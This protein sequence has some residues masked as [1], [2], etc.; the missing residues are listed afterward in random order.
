MPPKAAATSATP[1]AKPKPRA[2][3]LLLSPVNN[4]QLANLCGVLDENALDAADHR[5]GDGLRQ[6]LDALLQAHQAF[7]LHF[8]RRVVGE[9]GGGCPGAG[10]VEEGKRRVETDIVDELHRF[11]EILGSLAREADD[12]V[13]RQRQVGACGAQLAH[14]TLV[15]DRG[16]AALHRRQHAVRSRLDR[17]VQVRDQF[18]NTGINVDQSL[19]QLARMRGGVADAFDSGDLGDVFDDQREVGLFFTAGHRATV[20]IDV[21]AEQ[22]HFLDALRGQAGD[23]GEHVVEGAR[24]FLAAGVGDD[25]ERTELAAALHDRD[26]GRRA[27]DL[28]RRQIVELLDFRERDVDLRFAQ[29]APVGDH[30][31]QAMQRLRAENHVDVGGAGDDRRAFLAGDAAADADHQVGFGELEQSHPAEVVEDTLL[32]FLAHRAGVEQNDVG[33]FRRVGLDDVFRRGEYVGDFVR[34]VLVHLAPES[35]D[36][37][38][39]C[40]VFLVSFWGVPKSRPG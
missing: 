31:W 8:V 25:A 13:R 21:L 24:D 5:F 7:D 29:A 36:E 3:E 38:F 23:F 40:H 19:R 30:L 34:I 9:L 20:G 18:G 28:G 37:Q 27:I 6:F 1:S 16:V 17:Q 26:E 11:L 33:V 15:L 10:A 35:A 4:S 2:I 22:G 32:R 12:E 14:Q 39:F